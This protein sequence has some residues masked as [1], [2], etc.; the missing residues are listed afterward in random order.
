MDMAYYSDE[1]YY[2][3]CEDDSEESFDVGYDM[4]TWI[5]NMNIYY[6]AYS[7]VC[8]DGS[9]LA[10]IERAKKTECPLEEKIATYY[11]M[12][13]AYEINFIHSNGILSSYYCEMEVDRYRKCRQDDI[14][15]VFNQICSG[16]KNS[17]KEIDD[18][19]DKLKKE[20]RDILNRHRGM[21][22]VLNNMKFAERINVAPA[23]KHS[24]SDKEMVK[25]YEEGYSII[26][27]TEAL[28]CS[29]NT[30]KNRLVALG[31][32]LVKRNR[33]IDKHSVD[34]GGC[35]EDYDDLPF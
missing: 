30:V 15:T 13:M 21:I 3:G 11:Q 17:I 32:K 4:D 16:R 24:I 10:E 14:K 8:S 33:K 34:N 6:Y 2:M 22:E 5:N 29:Y 25:L 28:H 19:I 35:I 31:I 7:S 18:S 12:A 26:Q 1:D 9:I 27:I 23:Y 20:R